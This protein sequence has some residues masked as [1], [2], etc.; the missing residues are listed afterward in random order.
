M[1]SLTT[2][3][4]YVTPS[5]PVPMAPPPITLQFVKPL[6]YDFRVVE[7]VEFNGKLERVALQ[8]QV[9]EHDEYGSGHVKQYWTDV[10]RVKM[11][12]GSLLVE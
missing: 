3:Q 11:L 7:H 12:N 4:I 5:L 9:W 2:K 6:S 8:V 10:P 1:N